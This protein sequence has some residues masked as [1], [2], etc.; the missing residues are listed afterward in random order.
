MSGLG[1]NLR[2]TLALSYD[3]N[4]HYSSDVHIQ[5]HRVIHQLLCLDKSF[6][7]TT[8]HNMFNWGNKGSD[9]LNI[10][11]NTIIICS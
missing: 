9:Y 1:L 4:K 10:I 6:H 8:I 11:D 7:I 3:Q 2:P 5:C